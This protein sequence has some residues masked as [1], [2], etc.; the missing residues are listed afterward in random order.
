MGEHALF[1]TKQNLYF[2]FEGAGELKSN[3]IQKK[4]KKI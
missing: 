2:K 4:K 1:Q 3:E